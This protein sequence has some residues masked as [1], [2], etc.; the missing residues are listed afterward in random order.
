[1]MNMDYYRVQGNQTSTTSTTYITYSNS[2][3]H[4]HALTD[5]HLYILQDP[6]VYTLRTTLYKNMLKNYRSQWLLRIGNRLKFKLPQNLNP[7]F[8][9]IL[10]RK[11]L[12]CNRKG[13][14]L[15]LRYNR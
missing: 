8:T 3:T 11:I 7:K 14:G 10:L 15:R 9:I 1:M 2:D 13:I 5:D 12:R 6:M 4:T